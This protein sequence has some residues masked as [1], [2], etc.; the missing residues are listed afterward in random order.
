MP[1][2]QDTTPPHLKDWETSD[3]KDLA[4]QLSENILDGDD[5]IDTQVA[6]ELAHVVLLLRERGAL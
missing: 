2:D 1:Q 5:Y 6:I 4:M 3:L